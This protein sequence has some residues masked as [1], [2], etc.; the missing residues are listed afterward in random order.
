MFRFPAPTQKKLGNQV[1][2]ISGL[3]AE[4]GGSLGLIEAASLGTLLNS[5]LN[6]SP[7]LKKDGERI[8]EDT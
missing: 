2:A 8:E 4:T 5:R 3:E 7:G 6:E 1:S